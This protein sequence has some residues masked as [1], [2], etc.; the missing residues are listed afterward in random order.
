M[1][2]VNINVHVS[3]YT[4]QVLGV[5]KEK[6]GLNDKSEA[7]DKFADIFGEKFVEKD[8]RDEVVIDI[9]KSSEEHARKYGSR[10][11]SLEELRKICE[12]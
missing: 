3:K 2:K 1:Q 8:V 6:Y 10:K 11:M 12:V 5:I 9:I 7:L 4:S